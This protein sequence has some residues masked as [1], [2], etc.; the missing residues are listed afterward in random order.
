MTEFEKHW[1]E[2]CRNCDYWDSYDTEIFREAINDKDMTIDILKN[3]CENLC[4]DVDQYEKNITSLNDY[5][6]EMMDELCNVLKKIYKLSNIN[7][8]KD[9]TQLYELKKNIKNI[10][11]NNKNIDYIR[12]NII[13]K[14]KPHKPIEQNPSI[15]FKIDFNKPHISIPLGNGATRNIYKCD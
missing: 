7:K 2:V 1:E 11:I 6:D 3:F 12:D 8:C 9:N 5:H 10:F 13:D 14:K 15:S 4:N